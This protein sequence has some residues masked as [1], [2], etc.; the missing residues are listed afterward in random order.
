MTDQPGFQELIDY[1]NEQ[2]RLAKISG[3]VVMKDQ[4]VVLFRNEQDK[5]YPTKRP[6]WLG[7]YQTWPC[8]ECGKEVSESELHWCKEYREP[9][10]AKGVSFTE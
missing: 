4:I 8:G 6:G 9:S 2:Y 7:E 5:K 1:L 3:Y 10:S